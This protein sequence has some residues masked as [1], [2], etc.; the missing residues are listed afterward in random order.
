MAETCPCS[1]QDFAKW[2]IPYVSSPKDE[3]KRPP[4]PMILS[5][6]RRVAYDY[7]RRTGVLRR[8]VCVDID[9]GVCDY[10]VPCLDAGDILSY[11][12]VRFNGVQLDTSSYEIRDDVLYLSQ[13]PTADILDGL[14]I[15]YSYAPCIDGEC[16]IPP[17]FCTRYRDAIIAGTLAHMLAMPNMDW[18]S[19]SMAEL[20]RT[21]Y[22]EFISSGKVDIRKRKSSRR[23][24]IYDIQTR[25]IR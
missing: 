13:P 1:W 25:F 6:V 12:V 19:S 10:P 20:Y 22:E 7:A 5:F 3:F 2:I 23:K 16:E 17:E 24:T 21:Q 9:C 11:K 8:T 14:C 15:D 18:F 4:T